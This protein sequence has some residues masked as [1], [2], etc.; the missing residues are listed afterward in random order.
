MIY[1]QV[2]SQM[3]GYDTENIKNVKNAIFYH[4][5]P[6]EVSYVCPGLAV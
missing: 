5:V 1:E 6:V 2:V 3:Q 4:S